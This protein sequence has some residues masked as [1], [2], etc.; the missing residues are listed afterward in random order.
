MN[1]H[2]KN[3]Q[4]KKLW[5]V[6][7]L[8]ASWFCCL[9]YRGHASKKIICNVMTKKLN[10]KKTAFKKLASLFYLSISHSLNYRA[11][12]Y[13]RWLIYFWKKI[14]HF[15]GSIIM[16]THQ[17]MCFF[18][19]NPMLRKCLH[20]FLCYTSFCNFFPL[21]FISFPSKS[22]IWGGFMLFV[23][24]TQTKRGGE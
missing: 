7:V 4:N 13:H 20:I 19:N 14:F 10:E 18:Q 1:W 5:V 16:I 24:W 17:K 3:K 6:G 9:T 21:S 2:S 22:S 23:M 8:P 12:L 11:Y 15:L